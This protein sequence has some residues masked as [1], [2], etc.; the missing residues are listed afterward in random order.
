MADVTI[1]S[2]PFRLHPGRGLRAFDFVLTASWIVLTAGTALL[3]PFLVAQSLGYGNVSVEGVV[4]EST[5]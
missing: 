4:E 2:D 3:V 5:I 1:T